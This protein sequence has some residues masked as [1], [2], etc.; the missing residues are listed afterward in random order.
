MYLSFFRPPDPPGSSSFLL[1]RPS[2]SFMSGVL[3]TFSWLSCFCVLMCV[4]YFRLGVS[5]YVMLPNLS[6]SC[7]TTTIMRDEANE[8]GGDMLQAYRL[9]CLVWL[10]LVLSLFRA[11]LIFSA[12]SYQFSLSLCSPD[13]FTIYCF[14]SDE[15][16]DK[17]KGEGVGKSFRS[18]DLEDR[19][20]RHL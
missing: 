5:I 12:C 15:T 11:S 4:M 9:M 6:P 20:V 7:L 17:G 18:H 8:R 3:I 14:F 19:L 2:F 16:R 1:C 13:R 10:I